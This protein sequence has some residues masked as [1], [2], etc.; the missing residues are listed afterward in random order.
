MMPC[1]EGKLSKRK[2][3][4]ILERTQRLIHR[5]ERYV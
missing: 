1:R 2:E 3:K 5:Q 4:A